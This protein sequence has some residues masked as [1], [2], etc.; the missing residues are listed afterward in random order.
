MDYL[1]LDK[2][3]T[4]FP[5]QVT[6][7]SHVLTLLKRGN[8]RTLVIDRLT[9]QAPL[10]SPVRPPHSLHQRLSI[11]RLH[12]HAECFVKHTNLT[13]IITS[14]RFEWLALM[15]AESR[16]PNLLITEYRSAITYVKNASNWA[17]ERQWHFRY[18][19]DTVGAINKI[20]QLLWKKRLNR[21]LN[22]TRSFQRVCKSFSK[23]NEPKPEPTLKNVN[24]NAQQSI[25]KSAKCS[26]FQTSAR[27]FFPNKGT[28]FW[29]G[30]LHF[31]MLLDGKLAELWCGWRW[32]LAMRISQDFMY[33]HISVPFSRLDKCF[34]QEC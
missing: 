17:D 32:W 3:R 11:L 12:V 31:V 24:K 16:K 6:S 15:L 27:E 19:S 8:S 29:W 34:S 18:T 28:M 14:L 5:N 21:K 1:W 25:T 13:W 2:R 22:W 23:P 10:S 30:A 9:S 7:E 33:L 4:D 26:D 20:A